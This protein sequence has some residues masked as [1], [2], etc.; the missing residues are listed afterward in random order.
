MPTEITTLCIPRMRKVI[1]KT[2]IKQKLGKCNF[3]IIHSIIETPLRYE[4]DYKKVM[5]RITINKDKIYGIYL[6]NNMNNQQ[7]VKVVHSEYEYWKIIKAN[8]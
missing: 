2:Y 7:S 6:L 3:G 4:N 5:I 8:Q 1:N